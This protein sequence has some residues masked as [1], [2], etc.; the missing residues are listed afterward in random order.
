MKKILYRGVTFAVALTICGGAYAGLVGY[1]PGEGSAADMASGNNGVLIGNVGFTTG[2]K[3]QAFLFDGNSYVEIPGAGKY[4]FGT[5]NFSVAY[6]MKADYSVDGGLGMVSKDSFMGYGSSFN[7][8]LFN[9]CTGCGGW[10]LEVRQ[11]PTVGYTHAR[12]PNLT[13]GVW[14]HI[15]GVRQAT[16]LY[17]YVD[18][19]LATTASSPEIAN[20]STNFPMRIGA[21]SDGARQ[22]FSGAIDEVKLYDHALTATEVSFVAGATYPFVGFSR[23]VD[24]EP[25]VNALKAGSAVP[26]KF[27]LGGDR[28]LNIFAA[29]YPATGTST[30][31]GGGAVT[32]PIDE[33]IALGNSDLSYDAASNQY[34][35]VWKTQK[36]WANTC[37]ELTVRLIDGTDHKAIFH[38]SL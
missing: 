19:Q 29:G 31:P 24:N 23:P 1:W 34:I 2:A 27:S 14:H 3:G 38:F 5:G 4:Q 32:N 21:L 20:V 12:I 36:A 18:G 11:I 9:E 37:R 25:T 7:G 15:V 26:L 10:G 13:T 33:T 30:C 22:Y 17:L 6:W 28:G 35:Y 8:W 16:M